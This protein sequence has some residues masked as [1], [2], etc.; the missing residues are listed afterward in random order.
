MKAYD[1]F[2]KSLEIDEND[3][4]ANYALGLLHM[5]GLVPSKE[6]DF[7]QAV[8]HLERAGEDGRAQNALGVLYYMAP[9]V[10]ETDPVRL[11][12]FKKVRKNVD[13]G[14]KYLEKAESNGSSNAA[15]NLGAIHMDQSNSDLFSFGKAYEK[16][17]TAATLG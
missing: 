1:L 2:E 6:P 15:Y 13:K 7:D 16:F 14:L 4:T 17:K 12:G 9:D 5:I 10:L 11:K 3:T 8:E